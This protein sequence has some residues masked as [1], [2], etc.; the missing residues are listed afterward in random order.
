MNSQIDSRFAVS[1]RTNAPALVQVLL[2]SIATIWL[3]WASSS[4]ELKYLQNYGHFFD[5]AAYYYLNIESYRKLEHD[6]A[7]SAVI[8]EVATNSKCPGRTIPY[9]LLAPKMLVHPLGHLATLL[10]V[11]W[12]F[13][14]LLYFTVRKRSGSGWLAASA[15]SVF[16]CIPFLYDAKLGIAAYWLDLSAAL[17]MGCA[18]LCLIN[19]CSRQKALWLGAF[20]ILASVTA[21]FRYTA[22]FY[23]LSFAMVALPVALLPLFR[24][25]ATRCVALRSGGAVLLGA[26]PGL[27]FLIAFF[28]ANRDHYAACGYAFGASVTQ[29]LLWTASAVTHMLSAP[30][31]ILLLLLT[32]IGVWTAAAKKSAAGGGDRALALICAWLPLSIMLFVCL[33]VRAVDG[34][35]PLV[36]F[37]P[38]LVVAAFSLLQR[39][40]QKAF[41]PGLQ[42]VPAVLIALAAATAAGSFR[43]ALTVAENPGPFDQLH[44]QAEKTIVDCIVK[45]QAPSFV[46]FNEESLMPQVEAYLN[47]GHYCRWPTKLFSEHESYLKNF[48]PDQTPQQ[49]AQTIYPLLKQQAAL[50][51][52]FEDP[53]QPLRARCFDNQSSTVVASVISD[54]VAKD[55]HWRLLTTVNSPQGMLAIY[56]AQERAV[57]SESSSAPAR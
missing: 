41:S 28:G 43:S 40:Q 34:Y 9:L 33:I 17:S 57:A 56:R 47:F 46:Q 1:V 38:A 16:S 45:T 49:Q 54:M 7:I 8:E 29:S 19:F 15:V 22:G 3:V 39:P 52:V 50:V 36:Y 55:H 13:L 18:A 48:Y 42:A 51:A 2:C 12:L 31:L 53:T 26:L 44:R 6:G 25:P 21:L 20:G 37:A 35:H 27:G 10:P 14:N 23:M 32:A 24:E 4:V 5:P 30:L 11:L